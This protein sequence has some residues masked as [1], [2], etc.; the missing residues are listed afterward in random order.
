MA[1]SDQPCV[2]VCS[3]DTAAAA[4]AAKVAVVAPLAAAA[5]LATGAEACEARI[6]LHDVLRTT[7]RKPLQHTHAGSSSRSKDRGS[8]VGSSSS[9]S[10]NSINDNGDVGES[11]CVP[12]AD[13]VAQG[14]RH[15]NGHIAHLLAICDRRE[16]GGL[17]RIMY[18]CA[19][20]FECMVVH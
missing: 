16:T 20:L 7:V 3:V 10:G 11:P 2:N 19:I 12:V 4:A 13:T 14:N 15:T 18:E 9:R 6:S 17:A 5:S 1:F 8:G